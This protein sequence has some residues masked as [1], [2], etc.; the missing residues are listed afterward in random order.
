MPQLL[1][2]VTQGKRWKPAQFGY[3]QV[4]FAEGERPFVVT[5]SEDENVIAYDAGIKPPYSA[6]TL[7]TAGSPGGNLT[8]GRYDISYAYYRSLDGTYSALSPSVPANVGTI[9]AVGTAVFTGVGRNDLTAGGTYS[10][11]ATV[12]DEVFSG[13]G[14]DDLNSSGTYTGDTA[15][16]YTVVVVGT[17]TPNTFKWKKDSGAFSANINMVASPTTYQLGTEGAYVTWTSTTGHTATDQWT[18][19]VGSAAATYTVVVETIVGWQYDT[20]KWKKN[21]GDYTTGVQM[22]GAAQTLSDGVTVTFA[23]RG[24]HTANDQ[25][26]IDCTVSTTALVVKDF[27]APENKAWPLTDTI[28][29]IR[30]FV[31]PPN[32]GQKYFPNTSDT[33]IDIKTN[34][35]GDV[36]ATTDLPAFGETDGTIRRVVAD[37][38]LYKGTHD[39]NG[40]GTVSDEIFSGSGLDDL[41]SSGTFTGND[42]ATYVVIL[43]GTATPNTFKWNKDGGAFSADVNITGAAQSL[44][45]GVVVTFGA[46]TGHTVNDQWTIRAGIT[47]QTLRVTYNQTDTYLR[48]GLQ[49]D[50]FEWQMLPG[51]RN[52]ATSGERIIFGGQATKAGVGTCTVTNESFA[53]KNRA[54]VV[55]TSDTITDGMI[56]RKFVVKG[57]VIGRVFYTNA[58]PFDGTVFY[59][60]DPWNGS[61]ITAEDDYRW[62]G[63]QYIW[64]TSNIDL[65][66]GLTSVSSTFP[67]CFNPES[68]LGPELEIGDQ[69]EIKDIVAT[70]SSVIVGMDSKF[71]RIDVSLVAGSFREK[72]VNSIVVV[73]R[74]LGTVSYCS[75]AGTN[76]NTVLFLGS[77]GL[78]LGT[79]NNLE[80]VTDALYNRTFFRDRLNRTTYANARG[81]FLIEDQANYYLIYYLK[82]TSD[83]TFTHCVLLDLNEGRICPYD[84][85]RQFTEIV[86]IKDG[87]G[88]PICGLYGDTGG[89]I[90]NFLKASTFTNNGTNY[91]SH[92]QSGALNF[93]VN[94]KKTVRGVQG[95]RLF[96]DS[97]YSVTLGV[98]GLGQSMDIDSLPTPVTR[99]ITQRD[100]G[101]RVNIEPTKWSEIFAFRLSAN[102]VDWPKYISAI[103]F[104]VFPVETVR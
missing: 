91:S 16:T 4:W 68:Y 99:A 104:I 20:F 6:P 23:S 28:D 59:L 13:S 101:F 73:E 64:A 89:N 36:A 88:A 14:L 3:Q 18:I 37:N 54:K 43:T 74:N 50:L 81:V 35:G 90:G 31:S 39:T 17:G 55:L 38:R 82:D 100:E 26:T 53:G 5:A 19:S 21:D 62:E 97:A 70:G 72:G 94:F 75:G 8:A 66:V 71:I 65:K 57:M 77:D 95:Y 52:A 7:T 46:T 48:S 56:W 22:T 83:S 98:Y 44:S 96:K 84:I 67:Q 102:A 51:V 86:Q 49:A 47:W 61:A 85:G 30:L 24:Y 11:S 92:W 93:G 41:E 1:K 10:G 40:A 63:D 103:D 12:G 2:T 76:T 25:W 78:I 42:P 45:S 69:D 29:Q 32:F 80:Q 60:K 87:N 79:E 15:G 9:G 33:L 58:Y 27:H 34:R